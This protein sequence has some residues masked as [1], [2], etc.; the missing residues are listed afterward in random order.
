MS[1]K[2]RT[3][4]TGS[5]Q[6]WQIKELQ[7]GVFALLRGTGHG[8][9]DWKWSES[10]A[11][12]FPRW[13]NTGRSFANGALGEQSQFILVGTNCRETGRKDKNES[14][15]LFAGSYRENSKTAPF[16]NGAGL[17]G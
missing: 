7:N 13:Q 11:G 16:A 9:R 17:I 6:E 4:A 1:G 15:Y 14:L 5:A 12:V 8:R 3:C 2:E 10:S